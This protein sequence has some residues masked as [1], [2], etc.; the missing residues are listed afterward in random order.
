MEVATVQDLF[1]KHCGTYQISLA[2]LPRFN[3]FIRE[4]SFITEAEKNKEFF[5]ANSIQ[6]KLDEYKRLH[7]I[8]GLTFKFEDQDW[9]FGYGDNGS[10]E[11]LTLTHQ[12]GRSLQVTHPGDEFDF[13]VL[14]EFNRLNKG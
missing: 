8:L 10:D 9:D 5:L 12:N 1:I 7:A 3:D 14:D 6:R 13:T 4:V 2:D 11:I